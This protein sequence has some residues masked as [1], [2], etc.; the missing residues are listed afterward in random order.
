MGR[1]RPQRSNQLSSLSHQPIKD[2]WLIGVERLS[3]CGAP[4][5]QTINSMKLN[6]LIS[7]VSWLVLFA[8]RLP[9]FVFIP[10]K[11]FWMEWKT[12]GGEREEMKFN[13]AASIGWVQC[14]SINFTSLSFSYLLFHHSFFLLS[15]KEEGLIC[16]LVGGSHNPL[17]P[18]RETNQINPFKEDERRRLL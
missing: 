18:Q 1:W 12:A 14:C 15:T 13:G 17:L 6:N 5:K 4:T 7:L 9:S 10:S 11:H 16:L 8:V 2:I 3:C